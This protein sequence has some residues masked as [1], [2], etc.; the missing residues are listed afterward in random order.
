MCFCFCLL[1]FFCKLSSQ[2]PSNVNLVNLIMNHLRFLNMQMWRQEII[3]NCWW[4]R[5]GSCKITLQSEL[6]CTLIAFCLQKNKYPWMVALMS[7][8]GAQFCG[9]TLVAS[10]YVVTAA[11]CMFYDQNAQQPVP[12]TEVLLSMLST[13]SY[14]I[15]LLSI[16]FCVPGLF[17]I[18]PPLPRSM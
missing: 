6:I 17:L 11:H 13:T 2:H 8:S 16:V 3:K 4:N 9:G 7:S 15:R 1:H 5:S 18:F 14:K 10:K 12:K